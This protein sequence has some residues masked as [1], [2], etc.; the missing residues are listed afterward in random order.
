MFLFISIL[1]SFYS[2]SSRETADIIYTNGKIYTVNTTQPW[3]EAVAIKDG[4]FLKVGSTTDVEAL[5]DENTEVV[6]LE[7]KFVMPGLHDAHVHLE[8]AYKGD[9]LEDALL[10]YPPGI[11]S[12]SKLQE[13]LLD[14]ANKN[15]ELK[16]LFAQNL[17]QDIFPTLHRLNNLLMK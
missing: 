5:T 3:A 7:G 12:I 11:K 15:P 1:S 17:P 16:I 6:D 9:I 10:T 14:Y 8:Q 4:K 13:L 2:C